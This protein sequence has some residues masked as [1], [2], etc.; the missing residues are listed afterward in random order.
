MIGLVL[1]IIMLLVLVITVIAH[2]TARSGAKA[3]IKNALANASAAAK[4]PIT[5]EEHAALRHFGY[6]LGE[7]AT[8]INL[9]GAIEKS[10]LSVNGQA[11]DSYYTLGDMLVQL[12]GQAERYIGETNLV[13][14]ATD[15]QQCIIIDLN[16]AY[17]LVAR[18]QIEAA[19]LASLARLQGEEVGVI[20]EQGA[21]IDSR[22][23]ATKAE[24]LAARTHYQSAFLYPAAKVWC[25]VA[26]SFLLLNILLSFSSAYANW[27]KLLQLS[28]VVLLVVFYWLV[29]RK[30][31]VPTVLPYVSRVSGV[32]TQVTDEQLV[33]GNLKLSYPRHWRK[34]FKRDSQVVVEVLANQ[35]Q[36]IAL[37]EHLALAQESHRFRGAYRQRFG[38]VF[39]LFLLCAWFTYLW[40]DNLGMHWHYL[41]MQLDNNAQYQFK[42]ANEVDKHAWQRGDRVVISAPARCSWHENSESCELLS[43]AADIYPPLAPLAA[44]ED[45]DALQK[46]RNKYFDFHY[47][48]LKHYRD[49]GYGRKYPH[50]RISPLS[51]VVS[52]LSAQCSQAEFID[53]APL[54]SA[55]FKSYNQGL[56]NN[57]ESAYLPIAAQALF[58]QAAL[59]EQIAQEIVL[60]DDPFSVYFEFNQALAALIAR[61]R[62]IIKHSIMEQLP[63][64]LVFSVPN[65]D[66]T[67]RIYPWNG[68]LKSA[69]SASGFYK[70]LATQ[71]DIELA[72]IVTA[73]EQV[74][75]QRRVV[76][77]TDYRLIDQGER[78]ATLLLLALSILS[79]VYGLLWAWDLWR[80]SRARTQRIYG[81]LTVSANIY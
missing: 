55:L 7:S 30:A 54:F 46:L 41:T 32:L 72:G 13:Q 80:V 74:G 16:D 68:Y 15:G 60:K 63:P 56:E 22:R 23:P 50:L 1:S 45:H 69:T 18:Y 53:C 65:E 17:N 24:W 70:Q 12:D 2:S 10:T 75:E 27:T 58:I 78:N 40:I 34:L 43:F 48:P 77:D 52:T 11:N 28:Q 39:S 14:A 79:A 29:S 4:R 8:V 64:A 61:D 3:N 33:I 59:A 31:K 73:V 44:D 66:F 9:M 51:Q 5:P 62:H 49:V 20:E 25:L 38:V 26:V 35:G 42:S 36:V 47:H 57:E 76:L 71:G 37:P 67:K 81:V 21:T 6:V 19:Q